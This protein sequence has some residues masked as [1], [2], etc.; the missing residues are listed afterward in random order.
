MDGII[1]LVALIG[2]D[3]ASLRWGSNS[4]DGCDSPEWERR[5]RENGFH[6]CIGSRKMWTENTWTARHPGAWIAQ[7][8]PALKV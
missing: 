7:D 4:N 6:S 1:L 5:Q 8:S 2:L 3:L